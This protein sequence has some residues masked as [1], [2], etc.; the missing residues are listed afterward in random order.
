MFKKVFGWIPKGL[1]EL[2]T[3][4][5]HA[6]GEAVGKMAVEH[7]RTE[8]E[9]NPRPEV[10][11]VLQKLEERDQSLA[12]RIMARLDHAQKTGEPELENHVISALGHMIS[13]DKERNIKM[14]EALDIYTWVAGLDDKRFAVF[15]GAMKHDP[16]A[17]Y[18]RFWIGQKGLEGLEYAT[19][20]V[21]RA[22][23][24]GDLKLN[25]VMREF[26]LRLESKVDEFQYQVLDLTNR[27]QA[28]RIE[29]QKRR[30][31]QW[32]LY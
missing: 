22:V 20:F 28:R 32:R 23:E 9:H 26:A 5:V 1:K 24:I 10:M 15:V 29:L 12:A 31:K 17:Q 16:I 18:L 6:G 27:I 4:G 3:F 30:T 13:H 7:V 21:F 25:E 19:G 8:M 2:W 14:N 11:E